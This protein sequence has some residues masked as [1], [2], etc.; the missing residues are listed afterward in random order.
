[1][2]SVLVVNRLLVNMVWTR[3]HVKRALGALNLDTC[4]MKSG[5]LTFPSYWIISDYSCVHIQWLCV[6]KS[7]SEIVMALQCPKSLAKRSRPILFWTPP[8]TNFY[9]YFQSRPYFAW[10]HSLLFVFLQPHTRLADTKR[11]SE[12]PKDVVS[13]EVRSESPTNPGPN[14]KM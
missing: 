3:G 11:Y 1:M 8:I 2:S 9:F 5:R 6:W 13:S 12:R 14:T 4:R 10:T 7:L